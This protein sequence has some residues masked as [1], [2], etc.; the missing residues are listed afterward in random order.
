LNWVLGEKKQQL[1]ICEPKN[2][3][4]NHVP[5]ESGWVVLHGDEPAPRVY[6]VDIEKKFVLP[7]KH[8]EVEE[9]EEEEEEEVVEV[10]KLPTRSRAISTANDGSVQSYLMIHIVTL[11]TYC[12][13]MMHTYPLPP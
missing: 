5:P 10:R 11:Y 3:D 12:S 4:Q 6:I 13:Q 9:E 7:T 1:Y 2:A 8:E